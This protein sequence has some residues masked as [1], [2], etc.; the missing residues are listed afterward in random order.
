MNFVG[1][2]VR[3]AP[4]ERDAGGFD[5]SRLAFHQLDVWCTVSADAI[6]FSN[7]TTNFESTLLKGILSQECSP[8]LYWKC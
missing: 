1:R 7:K 6:K 5:A 3:L 2:A 4:F 8:T